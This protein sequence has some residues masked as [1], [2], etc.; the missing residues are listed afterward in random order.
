MP[1]C[2]KCGTEVVE[3]INFCGKCGNALNSAQRPSQTNNAAS[4]GS[5]GT[6]FVIEKQ[7]L[8]GLVAVVFGIVGII[9]SW[10]T[11]ASDMSGNGF[12]RYSYESPLSNHEVTM[13]AILV[14]SIIVVLV[15]GI[16]LAYKK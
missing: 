5:E 1:F 15:G 13:A 11:I 6:L 9:Y 2:N 8:V 12:W 4:V 3:G 10:G 7:F 16:I 14:V